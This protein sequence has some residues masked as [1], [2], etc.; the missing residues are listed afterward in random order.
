MVKDLNISSLLARRPQALAVI[1]GSS[2]YPNI[3]GQVYF[4]QINGGVVVVAKVTG[5]PYEKEKCK[6]SIF[7][8]HIHE[9]GEC[10]GTEVDEFRNTK[11]HYNPKDCPHPY[12]AGDMPPLFGNDGTAFLAFLTDRF[13]VREVLGRTVVIH[14]SPDDFI[15]QP[16]GNS[17]TKIACGVIKP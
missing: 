13:T 3:R 5:L 16:S 11:M 8:F 17:G 6:N 1:K 4:Y 12:H 15:S 2:S 7:G 10:T 9:G 14:S